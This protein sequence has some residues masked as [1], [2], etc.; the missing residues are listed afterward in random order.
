MNPIHHALVVTSP[1]YGD[2]HTSMDLGGEGHLRYH[3]ECQPHLQGKRKETAPR[4]LVYQV[5][6]YDGPAHSLSGGSP[7][8]RAI[9]DTPPGSINFSADVTIP[10]VPLP[11]QSS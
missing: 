6:D 5:P 1:A 8:E 3:A 4:M 2:Y 7:F 11:A 10:F 9:I